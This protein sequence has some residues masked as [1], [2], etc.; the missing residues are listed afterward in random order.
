LAEAE[1]TAENLLIALINVSLKAGKAI[2]KVSILAGQLEK[3]SLF[4]VMAKEEEIVII[5]KIRY[6]I[7][8][9]VTPKV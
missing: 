8:R 6:T 2:E 7:C 3:V 4:L 1:S 9:L 5:L